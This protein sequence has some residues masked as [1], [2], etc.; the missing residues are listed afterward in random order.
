MGARLTIL[1][2][3][4]YKFELWGSEKPYELLQIIF[5][6]NHYRSLSYFV[7]NSWLVLGLIHDTWDL[8]PW[9]M[10]TCLIEHAN[11]IAKET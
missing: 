3:Y 9:E 8:G 1:V 11:L 4:S 7:G 2:P 5:L 6:E 10:K